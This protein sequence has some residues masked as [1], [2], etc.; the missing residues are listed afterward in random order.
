[1][2]EELCGYAKDVFDF[3]NYL[4]AHPNFNDFNKKVPGKFKEEMGGVPIKAFVGL[5]SKTY[6]FLLADG[7]VH[8]ENKLAKGVPKKCHGESSQ[9]CPVCQVFG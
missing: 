6:S 3:S 2:Y 8:M 4:S 9:L 7:R 1:M 5:R